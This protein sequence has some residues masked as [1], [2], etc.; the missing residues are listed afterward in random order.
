MCLI[1]NRWRSFCDRHRAWFSSYQAL[2]LR[3]F[4]LADFGYTAS[5]NSTT[6]V[7]LQ[8]R[9]PPYLSWGAW[10]SRI[11]GFTAL[12][13][14]RQ[15]ARGERDAWMKIS[16]GMRALVRRFPLCLLV[17]EIFGI[18][19]WHGV[20]SRRIPRLCFWNVSG[21]R[22]AVWWWLII[23]LSLAALALSTPTYMWKSCIVW[24]LFAGFMLCSSL[25]L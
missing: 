14:G 20:W 7:S 10:V 16:T 9:V 6:S 23:W 24:S 8:T 18:L 19:T 15:R 3:I 17:E 21:Y 22:P 13:E 5:Q 1:Y 25:L 11:W 4:R 12:D 2:R